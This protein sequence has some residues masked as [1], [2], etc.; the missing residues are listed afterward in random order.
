MRRLPSTSSMTM[1]SSLRW[2]VATIKRPSGR[3]EIVEVD[4]GSEVD[5]KVDGRLP[6]G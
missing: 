6:A 5:G 1:P 3:A 4:F 2:C